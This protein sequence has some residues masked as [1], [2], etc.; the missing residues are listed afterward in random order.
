M[1]F[2]QVTTITRRTPNSLKI[3]LMAQVNDTDVGNWGP[4]IDRADI[5]HFFKLFCE[6][7][8]KIRHPYED[9][10]MAS[11]SCPWS[12]IVRHKE[13][14]LAVIPDN[15]YTASNAIIY[16]WMMCRHFLYAIDENSNDPMPL[17]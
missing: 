9:I 6:E 11:T 2:R 10:P 14:I 1:N 17:G 16:L 13:Y 5:W 15:D 3:N 4:A 7:V 12:D 8:Y